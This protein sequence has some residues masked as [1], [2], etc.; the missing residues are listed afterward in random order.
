MRTNFSRKDKQLKEELPHLFGQPWYEWAKSFFDAR[1]KFCFLVAS[2]QSSKSSTQIRKIIDWATNTKKWKHLWQTKPQQ[3]WYLYPSKVV[4]T[5][6]FEEKW[7]PEFLP[8]GS[9][10]TDPV[11]GWEAI[12]KQ[13]EI[14]AL[15]F[16]SGVTIYF[17]T[18][19]QDVQNLQTS[20]LHYIACDE[21]APFHLFNELRSRLTATNGYWSMVFTAT[22]GQDEWR[23]TM[24]PANESEE[25][26]KGAWKRRVSLYD[27]L[28][29]ANGRPSP[30]TID[31]IKQIEDSCSSQAEIQKRVMG[32]F[33]VSAG[34]KYPGFSLSRNVIEPQEIPPDWNI[35]TGTDIGSGGEKNH[36][37]AICFIATSPDFKQGYVFRGWR[38]DG[39]VTTSYDIL[40]KHRELCVYE[41]RQLYPVIK[42]YD[43]HNKD[44]F[45][46]ASRSGEGFTPADKN[47]NRGENLLNTLFKTGMLKLFGDDPEL[48]KLVIELSSL[49]QK[50][51]KNTAHDDFIDAL[52]YT[53]AAVPWNFD[54]LPQN[55][56]ESARKM[57]NIDTRSAQQVW[58]DERR[59]GPM[60][61]SGQGGDLEDI[62]GEWTD[63]L[64]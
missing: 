46:V 63:L 16:N 60:P 6:E 56:V 53:A 48:S 23:R 38:G 5:T 4:A 33:V 58:W 13:K 61:G 30:W 55:L 59:S 15:R 29:Y 34:L 39:V 54:G 24:E 41:G 10:K 9:M 8:R 36:P 1:E 11:Y 22:L 45:I 7:V 17:K 37:A 27:C 18:Y 20:T 21:E 2:N 50:T 40:Q 12:Y 43:W 28:Y 31:R 32:R 25:L 62:F 42:S 52:R 44:F 47:R 49:L 35:Y 26:F 64:D 19:E 14:F 3:F 51:A 57:T